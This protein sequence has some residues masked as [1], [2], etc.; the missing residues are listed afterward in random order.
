[1]LGE[2]EVEAGEQNDD[3][4]AERVDAVLMD[5]ISNYDAEEKDLRNQQEYFSLIVRNEG[6]IEKAEAQYEAEMLFRTNILISGSR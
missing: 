2:L 3:N 5:L 4:Y 1:M 6:E